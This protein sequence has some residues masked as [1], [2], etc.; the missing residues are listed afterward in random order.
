MIK[1]ILFV[2]A[3]FTILFMLFYLLARVN[4]LESDFKKQEEEM[5]SD[6]DRL[7]DWHHDNYNR[8]SHLE[9]GVHYIIKKK[10]EYEDEYECTRY[11][12]SFDGSGAPCFGADYYHNALKFSLKRAK[13]LEEQWNVTIINTMTGEL[14]D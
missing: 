9:T 10:G 8:I 5:E 1:L 3:V 13:E 11:L 7:R 4:E 12:N 6:I 14:I 2:V